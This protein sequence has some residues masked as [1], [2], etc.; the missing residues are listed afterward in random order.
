MLVIGT[1]E[2]NVIYRDIDVDPDTDSPKKIHD[3]L[4]KM[5][6]GKH[7]FSHILVVIDD[8]VD[9][10]FEDGSDYDIDDDEEDLDSGENEEADLDN[11]REVSDDG[12]DDEDDE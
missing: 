8:I 4:K 10:H 11:L 2:G 12:F 7:N 6:G 9:Y 3:T 5:T 1:Y